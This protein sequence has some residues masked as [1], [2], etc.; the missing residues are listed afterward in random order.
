[1]LSL[2]S[3]S[4]RQYSA[5][6]EVVPRLGVSQ[7]NALGQ[8]NPMVDHPKLGFTIAQSMRYPTPTGLDFPQVE[9]ISGFEHLAAILSAAQSIF[10]KVSSV[11][12]P[13]RLGLGGVFAV[14]RSD[15][16]EIA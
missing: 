9:P 14:L 6:L 16:R 4:N 3:T 5:Q 2:T 1:M 10:T 13:S 15:L 12:T 7:R 8:G 11:A